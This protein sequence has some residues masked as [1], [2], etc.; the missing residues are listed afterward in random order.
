LG[1]V[2]TGNPAY[3][4]RFGFELAPKNVPKEEP[5]EFFQLK[6]LSATKAEGSFAFHSAFYESHVR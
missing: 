1:C 2:L 6:L 5:R 4:Q 3:Y